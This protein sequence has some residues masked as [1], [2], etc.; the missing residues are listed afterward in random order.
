MKIAGIIA[1]HTLR[2]YFDLSVFFCP[3]HHYSA[4]HI[5]IPNMQTVCHIEWYFIYIGAQLFLDHGVSRHALL[6]VSHRTDFDDRVMCATCLFYVT[7][8]IMSKRTRVDRL[9]KT[10]TPRGFFVYILCLVQHL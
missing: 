3:G 8:D 4:L 2:H 7:N 1:Y 9:Y 5:I 6:T 10:C